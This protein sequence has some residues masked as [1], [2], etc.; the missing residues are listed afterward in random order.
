MLPLGSGYLVVWELSRHGPVTATR[1]NPGLDGSLWSAEQEQKCI[2]LSVSL[3][4]S[5]SHSHS[6]CAHSLFSLLQGE[7]P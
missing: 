3:H 4:V 1:H 6:I 7:P 5:S 2:H